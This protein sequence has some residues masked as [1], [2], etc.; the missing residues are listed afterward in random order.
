MT[1]LTRSHWLPD[2]SSEIVELATG[3][4][5]R[6]AAAA[7]PDRTALV[8]VVPAG[9][10]SPTGAAATDRRWTYA[11][12]LVDAEACG[13]WLSTRF[14]PGEHICLWAPNVAEWIIVQYGAALAGLV[15][16]TANPALRT[17]ELRHVLRQS[18]A[19]GL[20][21]LP[22]FRGYD[23]AAAAREVADDVRELVTLT[24]LVDT[25]AAYRTATG[26]LPDVAPGSPAQIQF[27]S[28][29]TGKPKGAILAH[30]GLVT[31]AAF[32]A[33]RTGQRGDVVV[34][35]MPLFHTAGSVLSVLGAASARST[36]VL[37][38]LFDPAL[39]LDA[40]ER[41]GGSVTSGV[42]T[43]IAAMLEE[44]RARPRDLSS[45][46]VMSSGGAPVPAELAERVEAGFGCPLVTVYGQTELSPIICATGPADSAEDRANTSGL[47]LPQVEVA[48]VDPRSGQPVPVGAE[49]EIRARGYQLMLGYIGDTAATE[50]TIDTDGWLRTGDVGRMDET[51]RLCITGRLGD[52]IIR[53]GENIYPAE[54][55][56]A[57]L[58]HP[59]IADVAV[60][61]LPDAHWG[62]I[63]AAAVRLDPAK[64]APDEDALR[65]HCRALL[66]PH[67]TPA[68]WFSVEAFPLTASGKVQKFALRELALAGA[69]ARAFPDARRAAGG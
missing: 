56:A 43:M 27:T 50:A 30:R 2:R 36:L 9:L 62:E 42:P 68:T 17:A 28:G 25:I 20:L 37:P 38:L 54:I 5:L 31:N 64:E 18:R 23:M 69:L 34:T 33:A 10:A 29:T 26:R 58:R 52:M 35:P 11:E 12:L 22:S 44:Q 7:A 66:A 8:E 40:I 45:L 47:P 21:F 46:R 1:H 16:V 13:R 6:A 49:G 61:G 24:G 63:V 51:G 19:V 60:F 41:E 48:I 67:K 32:M 59:A 65:A 4:A 55:E 39:M 53:G 15:L 3:G 57:M 14:R